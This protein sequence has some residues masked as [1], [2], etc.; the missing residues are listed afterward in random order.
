M[1][2]DFATPMPRNVSGGRY[3][4]TELAAGWGHFSA[5]RDYGRRGGL[6]Q[7]FDDA[8]VTVDWE[9]QI[10]GGALTVALVR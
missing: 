10:D 9:R 5:F 8:G 3:H 6:A 7:L 2:V 1:V 4:M